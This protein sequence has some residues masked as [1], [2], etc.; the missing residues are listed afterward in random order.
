MYQVSLMGVGILLIMMTWIFMLKPSQ[1]DE[2]RDMLFDLRDDDLREGFLKHQQ[3]LS[4]PL[5][6]KLR[7]VLNNHLMFTNK[8]TFTE[9]II[10]ILWMNRNQ[11][12]FQ[13]TVDNHH[14]EFL[15][16]DEEL[17]ELSKYVRAKA[18][19]IM[20]NHMVRSSFWVRCLL[21][22]FSI[23]YFFN[24]PK[25]ETKDVIIVERKLTKRLMQDVESEAVQSY[26]EG[27]S[28]KHAF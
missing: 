18:A 25:K 23:Y 1:L 24:K 21:F 6:I 11:N 3:G 22:V 8:L 12:K 28:S 13:E 2:T 17:N 19:I 10:M 26:V 20:V 16:D 14:D 5:Y 7:Q 9:F 4:H 15:C 27:L